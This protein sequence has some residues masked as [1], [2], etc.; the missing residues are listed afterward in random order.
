MTNITT[1]VQDE[2]EK[3]IVSWLPGARYA[4]HCEERA[5]I[6]TEVTYETYN[7]STTEDW[8]VFNYVIN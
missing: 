1:V 4:P 2:E 3:L 6:H 5:G 7:R 8:L